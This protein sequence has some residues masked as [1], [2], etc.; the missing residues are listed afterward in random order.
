MSHLYVKQRDSPMGIDAFC[1]L[2]GSKVIT[3]LIFAGG[4]PPGGKTV[5]EFWHDKFDKTKI[6]LDLKPLFGGPKENALCN[7]CVS[8]G[9]CGYCPNGPPAEYNI[10]WCFEYNDD[11]G[12]LQS[13]QR[14]AV[15]LLQRYGIPH[16]IDGRLISIEHELKVPKPVIKVLKWLKFKVACFRSNNNG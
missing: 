5:G 8:A 4:P 2:Q 11:D 3:G 6:V 10:I 7:T 13:S 1:P 15:G 12:Q 14:F 9:Y 16:Y